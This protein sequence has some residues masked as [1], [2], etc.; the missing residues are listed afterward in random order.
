M[1]FAGALSGISARDP[2]FGSFMT[3]LFMIG[4]PEN[5][6]RRSY[7]FEP[8][9]HIGAIIRDQQGSRAIKAA[10]SGSVRSPH[11]TAVPPGSDS[12]I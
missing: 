10:V 9:V 12:A 11:K 7:K 6:D 8:Q 4:G 1:G 5:T 2:E 3:V